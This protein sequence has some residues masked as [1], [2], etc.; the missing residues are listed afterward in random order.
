M[1]RSKDQTIALIKQMLQ[2]LL[3]DLMR[4]DPP[5]TPSP[6]DWRAALST[7]R[8]VSDPGVRLV[9]A[10]TQVDPPTKS[11]H[12]VSRLLKRHFRVAE[13]W[14]IK[15]WEIEEHFRRGILTFVFIDDFLGTG[16]QFEKFYNAEGVGSHRSIY[17]TYVPLVA[18]VSGVSHLSRKLPSVRVRSVE[19]LTDAHAI[20]N[21]ASKCF[22]DEI[23]SQD[24]RETFTTRFWQIGASTSAA[25]T[26]RFRWY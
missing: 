4:L 21:P 16:E 26:R 2:R 6:K 14:I 18:H 1:Y 15:A 8:G 22:E 10:V 11:A 25:Q 19:S 24:P 12:H 13:E 17:T 5:P 23:H 3:P 7:R 20:F 9:I